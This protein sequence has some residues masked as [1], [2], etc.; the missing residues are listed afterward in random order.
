M[1]WNVLRLRAAWPEKTSK[2]RKQGSGKKQTN[3][4][5]QRC[6]L[7]AYCL[8]VHR[9]ETPE[10]FRLAPS[11]DGRCLWASRTLYSCFR[12]HLI[13]PFGLPLRKLL[14]ECLPVD[15]LAVFRNPCRTFL[16]YVRSHPIFSCVR[17]ELCLVVDM[18][19]FFI[20]WFVIKSP[21]FMFGIFVRYLFLIVL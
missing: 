12:V 8:L 18:L 17:C 11:G 16:A 6:N 1:G 13:V 15:C 7:M 19:Y 21:L 2:Q 4:V 9:R 3:Y 5:H 20:F 10:A 14:R